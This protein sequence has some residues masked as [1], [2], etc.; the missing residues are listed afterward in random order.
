MYNVIYHYM[1][2]HIHTLLFL[3]VCMYLYIFPD[4]YVHINVVFMHAA[5]TI[6]NTYISL[7]TQHNHAYFPGESEV[8]VNRLGRREKSTI[9]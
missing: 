1:Y 9:R 2:I 6:N 8:I 5:F 4:V 7:M 3:S